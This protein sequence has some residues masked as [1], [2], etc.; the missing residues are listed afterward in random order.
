MALS[1]LSSCCLLHWCVDFKHGIGTVYMLCSI[2]L[3]PKYQVMLL[4]KARWVIRQRSMSLL[5]SFGVSFCS[6]ACPVLNLVCAVQL[7]RCIFSFAKLI[8]MKGGLM[9][10]IVS[11][12]VQ[13]ELD[14]TSSNWV[15]LK[16]VAA[17]SGQTGFVTS[18]NWVL[19][20]SRS[21]WNLLQLVL[22]LLP[23]C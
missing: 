17:G 20:G 2:K 10:S 6:W 3:L 19:T 12:W 18:A 7:S 16:L 11:C 22:D 4:S 21:G 15:W 23:C 13:L 9:Y 5:C 14:L 8:C 1:S